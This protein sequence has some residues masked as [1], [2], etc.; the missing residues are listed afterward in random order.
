MGMAEC[1][2]LDV[3]SVPTRFIHQVRRVSRLGDGVS[4][5]LR[6]AGPLARWR[7]VSEDDDLSMRFISSGTGHSVV[8]PFD[9][10]GM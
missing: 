2:K 8:E 6:R 10:S 4:L 9:I 7:M 5:E 1:P 3:G